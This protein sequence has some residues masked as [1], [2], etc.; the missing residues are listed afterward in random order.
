MN[1]VL[2]ALS[3]ATLAVVSR[4]LGVGMKKIVYLAAALFG[5]AALGQAGAQAGLVNA[6]FETGDLTG[7]TATYDP[8]YYNDPPWVGPLVYVGAGQS[9]SGTYYADLVGSASS[10]LSQTFFLHKGET[11]NGA[12]DFV[13]DV[14]HFDYRNY[15]SVTINGVTLYYAATQSSE[16][17]ASDDVRGWVPYSFTAPSSDWYTLTASHSAD[18]GASG[19]D[20]R[21]D[22]IELDPSA[23]PAPEPSTWAM[24][25]IGFA[26]LGYAAFRRKG[27]TS[28]AAL[29]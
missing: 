5:L 16:D 15:A 22:A 11:I 1:R 26:G 8:S 12:A 2:I 19:G 9:Y 18:L 17:A 29:A 14:V 21:L 28:V 25:L 24:L 23:S 20:F 7:W 4:V 13:P 3:L 27:K 10:V 6:G